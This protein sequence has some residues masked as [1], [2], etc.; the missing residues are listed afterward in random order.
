[1][2]LAAMLVSRHMLVNTNMAV[3]TKNVFD[4]AQFLLKLI[5]FC[6]KLN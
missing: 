3:K 6:C 5:C 1:M 2:Y 4:N